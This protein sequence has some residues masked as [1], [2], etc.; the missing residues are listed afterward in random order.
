VEAV[1]MGHDVGHTA[2]GHTG[3]QVLDDIL[4]GATERP[5]LP[6]ELSRRVGG[7]KHNYQSLRVVDLLEWRYGRPGL[8]LSDQVREGILKHTSWRRQPEFPLPDSEGLHLDSACHLEGQA[9]AAADEVAQQTHDLEDGLRAGSVDFEEVEKLGVARRVIA[10]AGA[11][12]SSDERRWRR[13]HLLIR[14]MIRLFVTDVVSATA[15]RLQDHLDRLGIDDHAAFVSRGRELGQTTVWFSSEVEDLFRELKA[16]IYQFIIN[17][18]QVNRQDWRA[19]K[20]VTALFRVFWSNP[21]TLPSYVLRRATDELGFPYLR[22]SP[23]GA[24]ADEVAKRYH[25][26][27][28]FARLVADHVAGM[29]DRFALEEYRSLEQPSP[30]QRF[31]GE[32]R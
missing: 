29:S 8:N 2:F 15:G 16:F 12:Y 24:V 32:S 11:L 30:D 31:H 1:A 4:R 25:A 17:H 13:Q 19:R 28:G 23:I 27:P 26:A 3:E 22:D 14:G 20:V 18:G 6:P 5:V 10:D 21:L 7:F 9:V